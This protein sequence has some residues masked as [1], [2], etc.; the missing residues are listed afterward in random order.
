MVFTVGLYYFLNN[1]PCQFGLRFIIMIKKYIGTAVLV[2]MTGCDN[3]PSCVCR[4]R[5]AALSRGAC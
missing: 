3:V 4:A 5:S 2:C 1:T